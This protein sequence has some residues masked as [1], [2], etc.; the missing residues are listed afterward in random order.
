MADHNINCFFPLQ[1]ATSLSMAMGNIKYNKYL[2]LFLI[3]FSDKLEIVKV[4]FKV[5]VNV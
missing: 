2:V 3:F 4:Y 5:E 1:M